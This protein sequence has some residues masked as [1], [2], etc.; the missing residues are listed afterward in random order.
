MD[1]QR[2]PL[3][4]GTM[5]AAGMANALAEAA[6]LSSRFSQPSP[7]PL[8]QPK[9]KLGRND[10]CPCG[11]G[12]KFKNCHLARAKGTYERDPKMLPKPR[13]LDD[14]EM[15]IASAITPPASKNATAIA[16]M[17]AGV[18]ARIVWAYLETGFF[19]TEINKAAHPPE[20]IEKWEAALVEYDG[21]TPDERKILLAPAVY[22]DA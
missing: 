20:N 9:A 11:S 21:A 10:P 17:N 12:R 16:M 2:L 7:I 4:P 13:E 19:I 8:I 14:A 5:G 3:T 18:E 22:D 6:R 1:R 15:V